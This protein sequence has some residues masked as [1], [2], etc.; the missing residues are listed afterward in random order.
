MK[1]NKLLYVALLNILVS[2]TGFAQ[3]WNVNLLKSINPTHPDSKYWKNTS[4]S[5]FW[6]PG[7]ASVGGLIYGIAAN[8]ETARNNV[9][10][11]AIS[12]AAV[13]LT[14][15]AIKVPFNE[16]RPEERYPNDIHVNAPSR[17][18]SFPSGHTALAFSAATTISLQYHKWYITAPAYLWASSVGYSRMFLGK[19]YPT[20]VLAGAATGIGTGYLSHWLTKQIFKPYLTKKTNE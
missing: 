9:Y 2:T 15:E 4:K 18:H 13:A 6:L 3:N 19:H 5:A 20:D 7:I 10:E 12:F 16:K 8:D 1:K 14:T 11:A 17:G